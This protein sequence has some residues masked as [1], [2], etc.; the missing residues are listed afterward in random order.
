MLHIYTCHLDLSA[1]KQNDYESLWIEI[2]NNIGRNIMC[3]VFYRH[4]HGNVDTL[5][6][7]INMIVESIHR[8]NKYCVLLGDFNLDLLKFEVHPDTDNTLNTLGTFYFQPQILQQ[9]TRI[10]D[11]SATLID[12]IFFNSLEHFVISGNLC[13]DLTDHLPNFLIASK[14]SSLPV[15]TKVFRCDYLN[16]NKQALITDIQS[17][18]WDELVTNDSDPNSMFDKFY[19]K[20]SEVI[21]F[22]LPV[23]Q[24]SKQDL[25][26][27]SKPWITSGIKTSFRIKNGLFKKFLKTKST[28]YH[29]KFKIYRNKLNHLIKLAFSQFMKIMGNESGTEL[30]KLF[31]LKPK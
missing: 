22:H 27:R 1:Q 4:P 16:L 21:D 17:I 28:Y 12:N 13:Y 6:N 9:P 29:A 26:A 8:E 30:N 14:L 10:T 7:H 20:L 15:S 11:H 3:G 2:Q 24:L 25:K 19:N 5:L 18:D 23:K 31:K